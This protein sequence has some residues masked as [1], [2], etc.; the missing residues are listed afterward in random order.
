MKKA[1]KLS[2]KDLTKDHITSLIEMILY[3][4]LSYP[5]GSKASCG[6]Q[7]DDKH[8][9]I[10]TLDSTY[11]LDDTTYIELYLASNEILAQIYKYINSKY[12][13]N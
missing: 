1:K 12:E 6:V 13:E 4:K 5:V 7:L 11:T 8:S 9:S 2:L 10:I 3:H